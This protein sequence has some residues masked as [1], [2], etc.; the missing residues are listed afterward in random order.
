MGDFSYARSSL[1]DVEIPDGVTDI[2]Y[3]AF[4][5]CNQLTTVKIPQS[6]ENI[7]AYAF[8]HTPFITN[9]KSNQDGNDFL[10]VGNHILLA[11]KDGIVW[12]PLY[13]TDIA[14]ES[15]STDK[16]INITITS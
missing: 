3:G 2:G 7:Q 1:T 12:R 11:Y 13:F 15:I 14:Q 8:D 4:Y 9:W 6:V 16:K 5:H 10:I